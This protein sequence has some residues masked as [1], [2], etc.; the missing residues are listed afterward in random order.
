MIFKTVVNHTGPNESLDYRNKIIAKWNKKLLRK[1]SSF[2]KIFVKKWASFFIKKRKRFHWRVRQPSNA[3]FTRFCQ[4]ILTCYVLKLVYRMC[5]MHMQK[6]IYLITIN[7]IPSKIRSWFSQ[8]R[9][10]NISA[11]YSTSK[12]ITSLLILS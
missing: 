12:S 6:I 10:K 3:V 9:K 7:R 4:F 1:R 8:K 11:K 5:G 2:R